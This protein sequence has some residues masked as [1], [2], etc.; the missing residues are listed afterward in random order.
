M[1]PA[2]PVEELASQR[3]K[4]MVYSY[5]LFT[6][7]LMEEGVELEK[8]KKASDKTWAILG[9]QT[10]EQ[11]KPLFGENV[12]I[13]AIQQSGAMATSVHGMEMIEEISG[14]TIESKVTKCP[15]QAANLAID[16]PGDWRLCQSGHLAFTQNMYKGLIPNAKYELTEKMPSGDQICVGR[17]SI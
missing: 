4:I 10:A 17:T 7:N 15:W 16:M 2:L 12:N 13:E 8:V 14:N 6:K 3:L 5:S 11:L 9:Q 1:E